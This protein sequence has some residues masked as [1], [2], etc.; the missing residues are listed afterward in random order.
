MLLYPQVLVK[1]IYFFF[2]DG[3]PINT[4]EEKTLFNKKNY[5]KKKIITKT[6]NNIA[7]QY[8][9]KKI[10][11]LNID[12]EGHE[13][14]VLKGFDIDKYTPSVVSVE[15]LDFDMNK[16][17]FKNNNI[18]RVINSELYKYF[19]SH[20]YHF[21]NWNHADLIFVHDSFKD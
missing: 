4:L 3:S 1:K 13:V 14:E 9:I 8:S 21:V 18:E 11:Y 10:D 15:F 5:I 16:L 2:H 17:E 6:L 12:V 19:I 20:N 7:I